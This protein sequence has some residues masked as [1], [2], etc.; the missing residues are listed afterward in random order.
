MLLKSKYIG[1]L[2]GG[3]V[4][5]IACRYPSPVTSGGELSQKTRDSLAY[6]MERHYTLNSNFEIISDSLMLQQLPLVDVLPVYK[7]ERLVVAE[8]MIQ[9]ED[10]V[11]S[12]WVK[13]AR[14][15][16]TMGWVYEKELLKKVVPVDSV[17]QFIHFFSNSHTITFFIILA[18]F[19]IGYIYRAIRRRK[20]RWVWFNDIDSVFPAVLLWLVA[21]AATLYAGIQHFVPDTWERFYYNPSLNPL[22]LPLVLSLFMFNVWG[23]I[24]VG[25]ATLDDLF[26]QMRTE[27]AF[28]YL[29]GLMSCCI[30]LYLFFTFTTYYYIGYPC[31][32]LYTVWSFNRIRHTSHYKFSCG[33]CG[34][35]IKTKGICPH[36]GA[37]NE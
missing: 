31:L 19:S 10:S 4:M 37:V 17:S 14:D 28:L 36:C 2:L 13:V 1:L 25:L 32:L 3:M 15:Q 24:L 34:A 18:L 8:F 29:L 16:E 26:H 30:F 7:G 5:L 21:T 6:L 35:M 11:D 12:V 22:S 9:P 27:A 33:N 20:L 23:I